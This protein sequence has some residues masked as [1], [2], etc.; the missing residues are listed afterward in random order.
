ME[1]IQ[2]LLKKRLI[3]ELEDQTTE[4]QLYSLQKK[5]INE[6]TYD[7]DNYILD[8]SLDRSQLSLPH[9]TEVFEKL[10][11]IEE[12]LTEQILFPNG[13]A[14]LSYTIYFSFA[15]NSLPYSSD[16]TPLVISAKIYQT[17]TPP[18]QS[19]EQLIWR[20][21]QFRYQQLSEDIEGIS[22]IKFDEDTG[23]LSHLMIQLLD[24][25][26]KKIQLKTDLS[27]DVGRSTFG[28]TVQKYIDKQ[29]QNIQYSGEYLINPDYL[30]DS[31]LSYRC[32]IPFK[33]EK[34]TKIFK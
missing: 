12:E 6:D 17:R 25:T 33:E 23:T 24:D 22:S 19:F 27:R 7:T 4:L 8:S 29:A 26:N 32:Y 2:S 20:T 14:V 11:R 16:D 34:L 13:G 31:D 9:S 10:E 21:I 5:N 3:E 15:D 18:I 28:N 1:T 30:T